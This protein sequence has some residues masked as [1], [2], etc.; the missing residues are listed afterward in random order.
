MMQMGPS[1]WLRCIKTL[2]Y[3]PGRLHFYYVIRQKVER[4]QMLCK[5]LN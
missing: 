1:D 4:W 3:L 2:S 5:Y